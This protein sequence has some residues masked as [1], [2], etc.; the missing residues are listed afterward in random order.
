LIYFVPKSMK[1]AK[2][3]NSF[4]FNTEHM[5]KIDGTQKINFVSK[6]YQQLLRKDW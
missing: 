5:K 1:P 4:Y 6:N 2:I 3:T